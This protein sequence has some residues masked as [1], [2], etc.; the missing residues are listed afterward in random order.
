MLVPVDTFRIRD[1]SAKRRRILV[2]GSTGSIGESA[3]SVARS[4]PEQFEIVGLV[5]GRNSARL[6]AQIKEFRPRFAGVGDASAFDELRSL[7]SDSAAELV[8]GENEISAC[9]A[10]SDVDV[11]V[12]AIVGSA[13]VRSTLSALRAGKTVALANKESL[14]AAGPLIQEA[15]STAPTSRIIPVDSEHAALFQCMQGLSLDEVE[16]V[17]LTAS[18]GPFLRSSREDLRRVTPTQA[19]RHPRWH[20]GAKVSIDSATL[21]NK[22]LEMIE[23]HW[24]FGLEEK[25]IEVI[26]HPQSIVHSLVRTVDGGLLAQ[27]SIPDMRA[28]IAY[29]LAYPQARLAGVLSRLDLEAMS[30]LEFER[31][32]DERFPAPSLARTCLRDGA[33][34]CA[35]FNAANEEAVE[36][37]VRGQ[38]KFT[39]IMALVEWGLS[40]FAGCGFTDLDELL[41]LQEQVKSGLR[42]EIR[43]QT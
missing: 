41:S 6:A 43:K 7:T 15:C 5:A 31:L 13:G 11:V 42:A 26:I 14:V 12:A 37:F 34:A 21:M 10:R 29:A 36:A 4:F 35:V 23:A 24:L 2:L 19:A 27:L 38:V 9:A 22:A 18:G 39:D 40:R 16:S 1:A 8:S 30:R 33:P 28:P 3:L 25:K 20:M 17:V 32:D